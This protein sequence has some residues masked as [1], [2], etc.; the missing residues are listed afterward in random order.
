M[1][2][3]FKVVLKPITWGFPTLISI[4][5]STVARAMLNKTLT[6]ATEKCETLENKAI[7]QAAAN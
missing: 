4:P 5:V 6:P 3:V 2:D 7:H 1:E